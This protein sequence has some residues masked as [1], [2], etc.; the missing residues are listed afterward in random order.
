MAD[1]TNT[2]SEHEA[3]QQMY[4]AM[5]AQM[6]SEGMDVTAEEIA[7]TVEEQTSRKKLPKQSRNRL[8]IIR[9]SRVKRTRKL[10]SRWRRIRR[11]ISSRQ[12]LM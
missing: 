1:M 9:R 10:W 4:Q 5:A 6:Q 12:K 7:Q 2:Q 8:R 3:E 11:S